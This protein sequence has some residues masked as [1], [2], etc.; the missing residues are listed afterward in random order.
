MKQHPKRDSVK[1]KRPPGDCC[2][3]SLKISKIYY[4][5]PRRTAP[6]QMSKIVSSLMLHSPSD[7]KIT[8]RVLQYMSAYQTLF[9]WTVLYLSVPQCESMIF[10]A[11]RSL[12]STREVRDVRPTASHI[13][14]G[15]GQQLIRRTCSA[16][17]LILTTV[18]AR[19]I[20]S[21]EMGVKYSRKTIPSSSL[22]WN[23]VTLTTV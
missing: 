8:T 20:S 6:R 10:C 16:C 2:Q 13:L 5:Y 7:K 9:L 15:S 19:P 17:L 1:G 12:E 14:Q 11:R 18:S 21:T 22:L 23:H 4:T 3:Q